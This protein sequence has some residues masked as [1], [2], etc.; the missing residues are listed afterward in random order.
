MMDPRTLTPA[1]LNRELDT[2]RVKYSACNSDLIALGYGELPFSEIRKRAT[3]TP[4]FTRCV[5][6]LDRERALRDE[7]IARVGAPHPYMP[8]GAKRRQ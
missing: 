7:I 2:L 6:I 1:K 3:E 8:N 5:E 4:V